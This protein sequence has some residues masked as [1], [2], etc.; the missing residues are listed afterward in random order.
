M[1]MNVIKTTIKFNAVQ[2]NEG[3]VKCTLC[4]WVIEYTDEFT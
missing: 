2:C 1:L 4:L 3:F